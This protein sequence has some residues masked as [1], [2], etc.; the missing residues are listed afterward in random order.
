MT[1]FQF[2]AERYIYLH[3]PPFPD[4]MPAHNTFVFNLQN[5]LILCVITDL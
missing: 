1:Y 3:S 2:S 4:V 5:L